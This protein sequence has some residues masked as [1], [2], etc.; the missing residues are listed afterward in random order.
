MYCNLHLECCSCS[1]GPHSNDPSSI[2]D[3]MHRQAWAA[4]ARVVVRS[5]KYTVK[6]KRMEHYL[7][8]Y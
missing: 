6:L 7:A 1:S 4:L 5:T 2:A 8:I 3:A